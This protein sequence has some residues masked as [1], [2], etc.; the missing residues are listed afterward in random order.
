MLRTRSA[1][2][3]LGGGFDQLARLAPK[4]SEIL[5]E[6]AILTIGG[7]P[8]AHLLIAH[9]MSTVGTHATSSLKA[10]LQISRRPFSA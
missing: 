8:C 4:P 5:A 10:R 1:D 2:R 9:P 3:A 7:D 6:S